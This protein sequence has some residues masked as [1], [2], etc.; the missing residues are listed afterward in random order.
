MDD[1]DGS[2]IVYIWH[3]N[4]GAIGLAIYMVVST[5]PT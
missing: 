1:S 5:I 4:D 3:V 2:A